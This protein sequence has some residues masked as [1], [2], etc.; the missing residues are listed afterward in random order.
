M[1]YRG[2]HAAGAA[3]A[4]GP[5]ESGGGRSGEQSPPLSLGLYLT[6]RLVE[7]SGKFLKSG[8]SENQTFSF[9]VAWLLTLKEIGKKKNF[10]FSKKF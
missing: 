5:S 1:T 2:S 6:L 10:T 9:L 8:L 4:T 7:N 3:A